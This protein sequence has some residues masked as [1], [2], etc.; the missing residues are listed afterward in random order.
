MTVAEAYV[1][2][3][4]IFAVIFVGGVWCCSFRS[5]STEEWHMLFEESMRC[6][7]CGAKME[8]GGGVAGCLGLPIFHVVPPISVLTCPQC[9]YSKRDWVASQ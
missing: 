1:I 9:G 6:P 3:S 8:S 2:G 4:V 5:Y 7:R